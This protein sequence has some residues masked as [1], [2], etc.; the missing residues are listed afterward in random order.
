[1]LR[2]R[3]E[4]EYSISSAGPKAVPKSAKFPTHFLPTL[5]SNGRIYA[6]SAISALQPICLN[7]SEI[8]GYTNLAHFVRVLPLLRIRWANQARPHT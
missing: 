1:M 4:H 3:Q 5:A 6:S 7:V 2:E 8:R